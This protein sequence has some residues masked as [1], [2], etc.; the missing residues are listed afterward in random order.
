[1]DIYMV[2]GAV[3][4]MLMGDRYPKDIDFS[5]VV[6]PEDEGFE[7]TDDP[8]VVMKNKLLSM[9]FKIF[10][11]TPEYLTIRARFPTQGD[12]NVNDLRNGMFAGRIYKGL[13]ADFVLSRKESLYSDGRRPDAVEVGTLLEDL[14][15]RDFTMNAIAMADDGFL[16]DPFNGEEA[17]RSG[18][19]R[20]VGNAQ[21][22]LEEDALRAVRALR[23]CVT[24]SFVLSS[25]LEEA[26]ENQSVLMSIQNNISDERIDAELKKMFRYD[27][28]E[29]LRVL[30][31]FP[32]LTEAMFS[33]D[34]SLDSTMKQRG[35]GHKS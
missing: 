11:L 3:R 8:F 18:L 14:S 31:K 30:S 15:R 10:V 20:P 26:L 2:G 35:F 29:S 4:D 32:K 19:I 12:V 17:I 5:V 7:T 34:V 22:R 6:S 9:G 27:T 23:F 33:G 1:M 16:F 25:S 13:T 24:K 28:V 21:N